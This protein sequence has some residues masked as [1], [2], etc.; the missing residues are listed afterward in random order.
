MAEA[1]MKPLANE[2]PMS[3]ATPI[4]RPGP[5]RRMGGLSSA[6]GNFGSPWCCASARPAFT[7]I[8]LLVVITIIAVLIGLILPAAQ[9]AREA[10]RR[11]QCSNN[12]KQLGLALSGYHDTSNS[13]PLGR[14][15]SYDPRYAG[16]NPPCTATIVDKSLH[17]SILP[18][19]EQVQLY[20]SIN[21]NLTILGVENRTVHT[22]S[23]AAYACP[24]DPAAGHAR[25]LNPGALS[26]YGEFMSVG[27]RNQ[28]V[29]TSYVGC[30]GSF[31]VFALPSPAK[32]CRMVPEA[33]AQNNGCF[34]DIGPI[35]FASITDGLSSTMLMAERST[36]SLKNLDAVNLKL[37]A[38]YGWTITGNWGD[39]LFTSFYP[40]NSFKSVAVGGIKAQVNAASSFH[41][42]G[43]NLLMADGSVRFAVDTIQSWTCDPR[44]GIP[45]GAEQ[46][47]GGWWEKI[48][49]SG[50]WQ[51]L[52]TRSGAEVLSSDHF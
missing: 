10:A 17:M 47:F 13:L 9:S 44:T 34:N 42:G 19:L 18:Y 15:K 27:G 46:A 48:P 28:M 6:S 39:T 38:E 14:V 26:R 25:D 7:L 21:Q 16:S 37:F 40:L 5:A 11:A 43:A 2:A 3:I 20:N 33:V 12:L 23:V 8:E 30:T 22:V 45:V 4:G 31:E 35:S 32:G 49:P 29:F 1:K 50:V 36:T 52:S 24:D 41:P 51:S